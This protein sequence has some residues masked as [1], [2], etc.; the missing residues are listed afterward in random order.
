MVGTKVAFGKSGIPGSEHERR[1]EA[2]SEPM[3]SIYL[4][5]YYISVTVFGSED[6][7]SA[8]VFGSEDSSSPA[9]LLSE[10]SLYE[11]ANEHYGSGPVIR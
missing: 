4:S 5:T 7:I 6:S 1:T 10:Y 3:L 2:E 11:Y 8:T 9:A